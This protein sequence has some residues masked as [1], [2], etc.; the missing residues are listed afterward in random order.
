M[1]EAPGGGTRRA[2]RTGKVARFVREV[3]RTRRRGE[4]DSNDRRVEA[5]V[6]RMRPEELDWWLRGGGGLT[7]Q[8]GL[9]AWLP[10]RSPDS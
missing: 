8:P 1:A 6:K 5:R 9:T 10:F 3:G 4:L 7:V 2:R